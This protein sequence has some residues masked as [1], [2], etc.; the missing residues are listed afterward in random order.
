M[1]KIKTITMSTNAKHFLNGTIS[2]RKKEVWIKLEAQ[3]KN[4]SSSNY[5]AYSPTQ[6]VE[7]IA[8]LI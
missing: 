7:F 8:R 3:K 5:T 2:N 6:W 1:N 4:K